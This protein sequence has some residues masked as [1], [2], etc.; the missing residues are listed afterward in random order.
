MKK[1]ICLWILLV[2]CLVQAGT[3][4]AAE[5]KTDEGQNDE[6]RILQEY[7]E[8]TDL[9][10]VNQV[11]SELGLSVGSFSD[12][13]SEVVES[14]GDD[15]ISE[16][17]KEAGDQ[18]ANAVRTERSQLGTVI[19][20]AVLSAIFTNFA[21]I[22]TSREMSDTGFYVI[23][24]LLIAVMLAVFRPLAAEVEEMLTDLL[25]FMQVLLPSYYLAMGSAGQIGSA[26]VFYELAMLLIM[27]VQWVYVRILLPMVWLYFVIRLVNG[28]A[29]EDM[30]G[31]FANLLLMVMQWLIRI[32]SGLVIGL[33][34]V[35]GMIQPSVDTFKN[36]AFG[37]TISSFPGIGSI[38]SMGQLI[39]GA[40]CI[41]KNGIGTAA[42]VV[43]AALAVLPFL[44]L[45]IFTFL[46][47]FTGALL[48]PVTDPRVTQCMQALTDSLKLLMRVLFGACFLFFITIA[49]TCLMTNGS[50]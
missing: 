41:V 42:L 43:L 23:Y 16:A 21:F 4:E 2:C 36:S 26:A 30:L 19:A 24:M 15:L 14:D 1:W 34:I 50:N 29:K 7:L 10:Q 11:L 12:I 27:V 31:G 25:Q 37:K 35:K 38:G 6:D 32:T 49:L 22:F 20:I 9:E 18:M 33:H 3:A 8:D 45:G 40:A 46:Y 28:I 17:V 39:L 44:K 47:Q 48:Q 5:A 13:L